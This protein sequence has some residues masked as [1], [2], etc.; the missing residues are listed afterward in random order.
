MLITDFLQEASSEHSQKVAIIEGGK[1]YLYNDFFNRALEVS[2]ALVSRIDCRER[3]CLVFENCAE[4]IFS[5]Y[6]VVLSG[7]IGVPLNP[8]MP[9][10]RIVDI[11][12]DCGARVVLVQYKFFEKFS[13]IIFGDVE[14]FTCEYLVKTH[15][16]VSREKDVSEDDTALI[17]YTSGTVSL[18]KGVELSHKNLIAATRNINERMGIGD[19]EREVVPIPLFHSFGLGR[20][21]CLF[22]KGGVLILENGFLKPHQI[23][24]SILRHK[25]TGFSSTPS[26]FAILL[27]RYESMFQKTASLLK[28]ME[29]GSAPMPLEQ[30]KH[31]MNLFPNT[32]IFM[33][34]GLTE[35]SRSSILEFHSEKEKLST[36]GRPAPNIAIKVCDDSG[37]EILCEKEGDVWIQGETV[38]KGYWRREKETAE[39][40]REGWL[41][42]EDIGRFDEE[43][44]LTLIGRKGDIINVGGLKVAA[45]EVESVLNK[46]KGVE[47]SAVVRLSDPLNMF[48]DVV[49]AFVVPKKIPL[50]VVELK[51]HCA[52]YL[53]RWKVPQ[54][55]VIVD[56]LP[57]TLSGK[58]QKGLLG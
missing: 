36:V 8:N 6:G 4:F 15:S 18:Q 35:A 41:K 55:I 47:E 33:H 27:K 38:M 25:A 22:E 7:A 10:Q 45:S 29:I 26:G 11:V 42:T 1:Q 46:H 43:G 52:K 23:I 32:N 49:Q 19:G 13:S 51:E 57:K 16:A 34:Y 21:R 24:E 56:S 40:L 44:Y 54:R 28:Y 53:E 3:V 48:G 9:A 58:I 14:I 5:F 17:L 30:K 12:R 2:N 50:L 20:A 31:L 39:H 37:F